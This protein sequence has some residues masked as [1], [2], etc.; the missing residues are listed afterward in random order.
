MVIESQI[1]A[2]GSE[3]SLREPAKDKGMPE[4]L[5]SQRKEG[6]KYLKAALSAALFLRTCC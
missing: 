6:A 3:R 1:D 5:I 4:L 2:V